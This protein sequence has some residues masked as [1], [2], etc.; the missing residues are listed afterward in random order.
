MYLNKFVLSIIHNKY[1][2]KEFGAG[3]DKRVA[4]PFNSEYKI[5]LKNKNDRSCTARV[6]VDNKKAAVLGD[7]IINANGT[8]D[9]ERFIDSSLKRG[10]KFKFVSL[11]HPDVD[12]PTSSENGVIKVEFRLAKKENGI[13]INVLPTYKP[14]NWDDWRYTKPLNPWDGG[15]GD[16]TVYNSSLRSDGSHDGSVQMSFCSDNLVSDNVSSLEDGATIEGGHSN[17]SFVY[18]NLDVE[19][20]PTILYLKIVGIKDS[21]QADKLIYH[22]CSKCGFKVK[23]SDKFCSECGKKL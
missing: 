12:D 3:G 22:Y 4:I 17:Q 7:L 1:P 19:D 10:K 8:I 23:R 20:I 15:T 13:K 5:R 2:V 6:F 21:K 11:D 9:L 16:F 18:S 14:W